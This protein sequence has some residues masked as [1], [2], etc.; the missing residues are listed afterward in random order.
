MREVEGSIGG[1]EVG[2]V[3]WPELSLAKDGFLT[4][5][6]LA[7]ALCE[8]KLSEWLKEVPAYYN[9]K[10]KIECDDVRKKRIVDGMTKYAKDKK[11][12]ANTIDGVR[13]DFP[14]AWVIVRA[15]GTENY[16]RVF[17]EAKTP[18]K[19]KALME[20]YKKIAEGF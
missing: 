8:K 14:D 20:E 19:A 7:E 18:D 11:L 10:T 4:G 1:E 9:E 15:S 6:K 16:V 13:L 2:G 12:K 17:A 3:I 5:A